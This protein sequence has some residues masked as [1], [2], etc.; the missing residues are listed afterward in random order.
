[1]QDLTTAKLL[2]V[3][4]LTLN[5]AILARYFRLQKVQ[6]CSTPFYRKII[7]NENDD[8]YQVRSVRLI[9]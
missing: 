2:K 6:Q 3:V 8:T 7:M 5:C 9:V 4:W 1:M